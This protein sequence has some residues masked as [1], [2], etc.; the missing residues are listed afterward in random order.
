MT[1][2]DAILSLQTD[3]ENGLSSHEVR[4]RQHKYGHNVVRD[5]EQR[6]AVR[7]LLIQFK[8]L[9]II[10]L[11][12][13]SALSYSLGRILESVAII[14]VA[15]MT[16]AFGFFMEQSAERAVTSLMTL[17]APRAKVLRHGRETEI[18]AHE[19]VPGDIVEFEAG[20]RVPADCK[21]IE[22]FD[23]VVDESPLTGESHGVRKDSELVLE[24]LELAD[25]KNMVYMGT[26]VLDGRGKGA[27]V[28]IGTQTE[29]GKIGELLQGVSEGKTPLE[30]K[31]ER[32]GRTLVIA[33]FAITAM[34]IA[35][36]YLQGFEIG[37]I[38]VSGIVLAIAAVPEGLP[39]VT[40]ITLAIGVKRMVKKHALVRRLA[41]AETLGSVTVICTDKTGTLTKNEPT[42]REIRL[43]ASAIRVS[44]IGFDPVGGFFGDDK[45]I[46]PARDDD[47]LLLLK[48]GALC[49]NAELSF[50]GKQWA[51]HGDTT[52]GAII[53][54]AQKA[55]L[56]KRKLEDEYERIWEDPFDSKTRRM[57]TVHRTHDGK[58]F[59]FMKGAPE[60]VIPLCG[61]M[62][63][64]GEVVEI[65]PDR[66]RN[67]HQSIQELIESGYRSLVIAYKEM[68]PE[69]EYHPSLVEQGL[70][71]L[72]S[73]GI[74]DPPRQGI[75]DAVQ[76]MKQAKVRV[77]MITGDHPATATAV[78]KE[79]KISDDGIMV[80]TG[81]ELEKMSIEKLTEHI[82]KVD[83]FARAT[84]EQK[85]KIVEAFQRKGHVVA[86][87]G[88]GVND[89]PALK[90]AEIGVAMGKRGTDVAKESAELILLDDMFNTITYAVESGRQIYANIKRFVRYLF[91][92]NISEV[93]TMLVAITVALPF[94]LL[95]LQL[96]WMNLTIN[97]FP[98]LAL[99]AENTDKKSIFVRPPRKH[100]PI[101][102]RKG[103]LD[104]CVQGAVM[105]TATIVVFI[106][107]LSTYDDHSMAQTLAFTTLSLS[108]A[109]HA[110]NY[111]STLRRILGVPKTVNKP[112]VGA[113][114][115]SIGLLLTAMYFEPL[116]RIME[117]HALELEEWGIAL[118]ASVISMIA[119]HGTV[120]IFRED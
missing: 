83:V 101:I 22:S 49:S 103:W 102:S 104:L 97:T 53:V 109:W 19:L 23:L 51:V 93:M 74:Y 52:E 2:H 87:T 57:T 71:L 45:V 111:S 43:G 21:L 84:P 38:F 67:I 120:R 42:L 63:E 98:A 117:L 1:V 33:V 62:R 20:D 92:C 58:I 94:P 96:L 10:L 79:M 6:S 30:Q 29:L 114:A 47:L 56:E 27:V 5:I 118:L 16:V 119:L 13:A 73:V 110:F 36:G 17:R 112:L 14:A 70:I 65:D 86:V 12:L 55:G 95:P 35:I 44:G 7:I 82:E 34:Y 113:I 106:W 41:A 108:Q 59:A 60:S 3:T 25:R 100:E 91:S 78:A 66:R 75:D 37:R 46:D 40:T 54:A 99:A 39:A 76:F 8:N 107:A 89:A 90:Q 88:D 69:P 26:L 31:I 18:S 15:F 48:A 11:L 105:T 115:L 64:N 68:D 24:D 61:M 77:V 81:S 72:G 80:M 28:S 85:L 50:D 32:L 4:T 9:P 116:A